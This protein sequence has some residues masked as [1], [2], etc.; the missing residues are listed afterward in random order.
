MPSTGAAKPGGFEADN[1]SSPPGYGSRTVAHWT[2][3]REHSDILPVA[4]D[5][6]VA[7][8]QGGVAGDIAVAVL[9]IAL[10][11][12]DLAWAES[13][14]LPLTKHPDPYVRGNA[15]L[16]FGHL[17]RIHG[18]L[19]NDSISRLVS[20]GL[21]D[22]DTYVRGQAYAAADDLNHFLRWQVLD[23]TNEK[24]FNAFAEDRGWVYDNGAYYADERWS[25]YRSPNYEWS[26]PTSLNVISLLRHPNAGVVVLHNSPVGQ[27]VV[28]K[29]LVQCREDFDDLAAVIN[30]Y[31]RALS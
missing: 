18:R 20:D 3:T 19:M 27:C 17:A 23:L 1:R 12:T 5:D 28:C 7:T 15:L 30:D 24:V 16:S 10:H 22:A 8:V 11:E 14:C 9:S 31:K 29:G 13:F 25:E 2:M 21:R 26:T 6:A 4:R